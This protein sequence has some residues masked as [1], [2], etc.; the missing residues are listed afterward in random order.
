MIRV[1]F[2]RQLWASSG[3]KAASLGT[4]GLIAPGFDPGP[5][6][7]TP[8]PVSLADLQE[9]YG[10]LDPDDRYRLLIELGRELEAMPEPLKTDVTMVRGCS[11]SVW[12]YPTVRD[13]GTLHFTRGRRAA[14]PAWLA[15][16]PR[17]RFRAAGPSAGQTAGSSAGTSVTTIGGTTP[18]A[19]NLITGAN[20][21]A[22]T[23]T[24]TT[25]TVLI[26]CR[27]A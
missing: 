13:D 11:A 24:S 18:G 27:R 23:T 7:T 16:T 4:L 17:R 10:F 6:L 8:D 2:I 15:S 21:E 19:G 26:S 25:S 14:E 12:V 20:Y 5:G 1:E 22:L 9:E 3:S